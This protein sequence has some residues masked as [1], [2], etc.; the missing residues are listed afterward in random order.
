MNKLKILCFDLDGVICKTTKKQYFKAKPIKNNIT[1]INELYGRGYFIKIFTAR[2]MGRSNENQKKA[3]QRGFLKTK[4]QLKK[5][6][7]K[8]HELIFG[9]P[10]Y[11]L[12]IDDRSIF[13]K[14]NWVKKI[15]NIV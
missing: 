10:S 11:D 12:F 8:Y 7:I 3:K 5:W 1:K 2:F 9:K 14:K 6:N 13:F 4:Q 15:D